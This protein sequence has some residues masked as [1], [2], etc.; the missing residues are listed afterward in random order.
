MKIETFHSGCDVSACVRMARAYN[1]DALR[2]KL[3]LLIYY[4]SAF[5]RERWMAVARKKAASAAREIEDFDP[6]D[7]LLAELNQVT[8]LLSELP[9]SAVIEAASLLA[10]KEKLEKELKESEVE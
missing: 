9:K 7:S 4:Y 10:R 1:R 5:H 2:S 3:N 8:Q 6:R